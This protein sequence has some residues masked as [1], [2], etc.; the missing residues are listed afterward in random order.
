MGLLS[1][2]GAMWLP[3]WIPLAACV[4]VLVLLSF[5]ARLR[6]LRLK[7][8]LCVTCGYDLR[9]SKERC[10]ECGEEFGSRN[11]AR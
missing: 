5:P 8:G 2:Y 10:P 1:L 4:S 11:D 6:R 9:A 7:R 3:L